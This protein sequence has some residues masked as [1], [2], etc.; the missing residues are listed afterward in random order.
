MRSQSTVKVISMGV[1]L[2]ALF[3]M[4]EPDPGEA[5]NLEQFKDP[6]DGEFDL[7]YWLAEKKGFLPIFVLGSACRSSAGGG[8]I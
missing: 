6:S 3:G 2:M 8:R 4:L 1:L 7:S 5:V